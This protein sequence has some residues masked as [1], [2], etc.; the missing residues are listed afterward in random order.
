M[1]SK[2][3]RRYGAATAVA[4]LLSV[5]SAFAEVPQITVTSLEQ[6][7]SVIRITYTLSAPAIVTAEFRTNGY[8]IAES[9][10][11]NIE[12]DVNKY[13]T[14]GSGEI[15]WKTHRRMPLG[16]ELPNFNVRLKARPKELPPDYFVYDIDTKAQNYYESEGA[17]PGGISSDAYRTSKI[18]MRRIHAANRNGRW[19]RRSRKRVATR[20]K[21]PIACSSRTTTTWRYSRRRRGSSP[22]WGRNARST[23]TATKRRCIR[24][25]T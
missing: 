21:S 5:C 19:G 22:G 8:A 12:G 24:R 16:T 10:Y 15:K 6:Q 18:V 4:G 2:A 20:T 7:A 25:I 14:A 13:I 3:C 17:L 1:Q 9:V 23:T 11:S